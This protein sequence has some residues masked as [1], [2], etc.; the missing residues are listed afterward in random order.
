MGSQPTGR[1]FRGVSRFPLRPFSVAAVVAVVLSS[2]ASP[3]RADPEDAPAPARVAWTESFG[4]GKL[5]W[6]DPSGHGPDQLAKIYGVQRD[7]GGAWLHARHDAT[8]GKTP[9]MH[10]GRALAND[11]VALDKVRA[12]TWKWRVTQHPRVEGDPW[13]DVAASVYVV[14]EK[15]GLFSGGKGFKLGWLAKPGPRGTHQRGLLQ[16]P[17][18]SDAAGPAWQSESVDLCALYRAEYG[19]SCAG[20]K[21]LYVGV[22]TDADGTKSVAEADYDDFTLVLGS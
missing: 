9:A 19:G 10:Y 3:S 11:G 5:A 2:A 21:V 8:N 16:V 15:P 6:G 4:G 7:G 18:R 17:L 12:L 22:V 1:Y 14:F 20:Q 13:L